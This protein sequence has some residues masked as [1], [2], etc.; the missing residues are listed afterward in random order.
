MLRSYLFRRLARPRPV[1]PV[2]PHY[3]ALCCIQKDE[4]AYLREWVEY[5]AGIGI[6]RFFVYDNGSE[7]HP[8][9]A[10]SDHVASGLVRIVDFPGRKQ[11]TKAYQHCID[12]FWQEATWIGFI[13]IDEFIVPKA[14]N[15][16]LPAFL[17]Q[18]EQHGGVAINWRVFGSNGHRTMD[19]T[20]QVLRFT[21]RSS[22][23]F[24][25]NDHIKSI[26]QPRFA[27]AT[28]NPH[29]FIYCDGRYCVNDAF[30][31][32][33]GA[34]SPHRTDAIQLNHYYCRSL[35]EYAQKVRRGFADSNKARSPEG[36]SRHDAQC[37]EEEDLTALDFL[38][39]P[40]YRSAHG[41]ERPAVQD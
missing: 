22:D 10:L 1:P 24:H 26:V 41:P 38:D 32:T 40:V 17:R 35:E 7:E 31:R 27:R 23:A 28:G 25:V 6:T 11:Q 12:H 36:F 19:S 2:T 20:S 8:S 13:D 21:R 37:N 15:G 29:F 30:V 39:N 9:V 34:K 16:D 33:D 14:T 5:H 18:Y 3:A 4:N